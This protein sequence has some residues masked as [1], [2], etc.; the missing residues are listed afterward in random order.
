LP[1]HYYTDE[2]DTTVQ[3]YNTA[4]SPYTYNVTKALEYMDRW[5][6]SQVGY[7]SPYPGGIYLEG[8]AG[9]A[10]FSGRVTVEDYHFWRDVGLPYGSMPVPF[11]PG[12]DIDPDFNNDG[13]IDINP[14]YY[15]Y[16]DEVPGKIY[17][18]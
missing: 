14:D 18:P 2:N 5:K 15:I 10:D 9:D 16:R 4:L 3:L 12:Q 17:F 8:A 1:Q 11:L 7:T 13:S 6:K